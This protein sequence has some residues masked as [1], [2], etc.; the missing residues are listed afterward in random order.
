[1]SDVKKV[2]AKCQ[3]CGHTL[4]AYCPACRGRRGGSKLTPAKRRQLRAARAA[5]R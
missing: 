2:S 1:M 4:V 3:T 5:K